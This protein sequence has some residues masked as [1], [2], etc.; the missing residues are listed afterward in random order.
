MDG[1]GAAC[2]FMAAAQY[3]SC[4]EGSTGRLFKEMIRFLLHSPNPSY[5]SGGSKD[6]ALATSPGA[7]SIDRGHRVCDPML[8][9]MDGAR[10]SP[11]TGFRS[12]EGLPGSYRVI[13][14]GLPHES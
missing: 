9:G 7:S 14:V 6:R 8:G 12:V 13:D 2:S 3:T 11:L 10:S 5:L 1:G 4:H